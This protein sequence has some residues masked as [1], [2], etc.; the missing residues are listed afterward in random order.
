[1]VPAITKAHIPI[2]QRHVVIAR[3]FSLTLPLI[4]VFR[5]NGSVGMYDRTKRDLSVVMSAIMTS[6]SRINM[7]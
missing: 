6:T 5:R 7:V 2:A 3:T 4:H 1:M